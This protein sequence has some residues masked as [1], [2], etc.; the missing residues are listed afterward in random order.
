[1][2][3]ILDTILLEVTRPPFEAM[4]R[5][6]VVGGW[7][8]IMFLVLKGGLYLTAFYKNQ[9]YTSTWKWTHL[10][11]D[12]PQLNAQTPKAVEQLFAHIFS[13]MEVPGIAVV[14]RRGFEQFS[15]S[16]EIVSIEGYIQFLIRVLEQ[17]RDVVEAA[18]YAQYPDAEITEIEDYT[19]DL[20]N[21]YPNETHNMWGAEF[22]LVAHHAYPIRVYRDFEHTVDKDAPVKDPMGTFLESFSRIGPGEQMW[23]QMVIEPTPDKIWKVDCIKEIKKVV[24]EKAKESGG[25]GFMGK[26]VDIPLQTAQLFGDQIFGGGGDGKKPDK[27]AEKKEQN[28]MQ[29]LTPGVKKVVEAMEEKISK[30]GYNTKIR[31]VYVARN[32]V[33]N[34]ARGVNSLIGAIN[35][36]NNPSSNALLPKYLTSVKYLFADRIKNERKRKIMNAYKKRAMSEIKPSF[37]LNIEELATIWHFPMSHVRVPLLQKAGTKKTEPPSDLPVESLGMVLPPGSLEEALGGNSGIPGEIPSKEPLKY[38]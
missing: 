19:K 14:Y 35:Q 6:F 31:M 10:A 24:G 15:F 30:I 16:F 1:M 22:M 25:G 36:F 17:Y 21:H 5:L 37:I 2:D 20:P 29:Y 34:P 26:A 32:E 13:I 4:L 8:I 28:N 23:Y 3:A 7:T 12:V 33:F 11:I 9:R 18:V 27:K 38:G